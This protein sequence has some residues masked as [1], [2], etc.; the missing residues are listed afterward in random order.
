MAIL[1]FF[2]Y[3]YCKEINNQL[4][5]EILEF[6]WEDSLL[7]QN[8]KIISK[9]ELYYKLANMFKYASIGSFG[10]SIILCCVMCFNKIKK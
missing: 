5:N 6:S 1:S 3:K 7:G 8:D 4:C 9:A 2:L 10:V